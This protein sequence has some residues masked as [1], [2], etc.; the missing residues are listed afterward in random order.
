MRRL[1]ACIENEAGESRATGAPTDNLPGV[2]VDHEGG[3]D[4]A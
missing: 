1:F 2:N 3:A 4:K